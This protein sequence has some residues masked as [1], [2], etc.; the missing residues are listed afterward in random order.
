MTDESTT[1]DPVQLDDSELRRLDQEEAEIAA[2]LLEEAGEHLDQVEGALLAADRA[3]SILGS[4]DELLRSFHTI[5]GSA[6]SVGMNGL[7]HL[8]HAAETVL[9]AARK[10]GVVGD[11]DG[12]AD[13]LLR[14]VTQARSLMAAQQQALNDGALI[15][16]VPAQLR[17]GY[18]AIV[19]ELGQVAGNIAAPPAARGNNTQSASGLPPITRVPRSAISPSLGLPSDPQVP[20]A[21]ASP[22]RAPLATPVTVAP[23]AGGHTSVGTTVVK[24]PPPRAAEDRLGSAASD[25][26]GT[27]LNA[28][29]R[30]SMHRV[31]SLL[32]LVSDLT[33]C[34]SALRRHGTTE[35][36]MVELQRL[37]RLT[38]GL[39]DTVLDLRMI[40]LNGVFQRMAL[41]VRDAART[42]G[43]QVELQTEGGDVELDTI[44]VERLVDPILH[45]VRNA[46]AHGIERPEERRASRKPLPGKVWIKVTH[47]AGSITI[48][49]GDDGKGVDREKLRAAGI[50]AGLL[51]SNI[52]ATDP[53]VLRVLFEAG[54]STSSAVDSVSGRGVGMD[55]VQSNVEQA[56]G[57]VEIHSIEG[58]GTRIT[59]HVPLTLA[60][61][62]GAIIEAGDT[63]FAVPSLRVVHLASV[64]ELEL[65]P[66]ATGG[67]V[68]T[69]RGKNVPAVWLADLF[70]RTRG[71]GKVGIVVAD[72]ARRLCLVV[73][74]VRGFQ[75]LVVRPLHKAFQRIPG[76]AGGSEISEGEVGLIL[77]VAGL[78]TMADSQTPHRREA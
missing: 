61:I 50:R 6:A 59:L 52:A 31:D 48:E 44:L 43:K 64:E 20:H 1:M 40:S 28:T 4:I 36:G 38:D 78:M 29:M 18:A 33:L 16:A 17:S 11:P 73:D 71:T 24:A 27:G 25:A 65:Q 75:Q 23:R 12:T 13:L 76:I 74:N 63:L 8:A 21:G 53:R 55:V 41:T 57:T 54:I 68:A 56:G 58:R 39:R 51:P 15:P 5:K 49:I 14:A 62:D 35:A 45:I 66:V 9:T 47:D 67:A 26:L 30:V 32:N 37:V 69:I 2:V 60:I 34:V 3:S 7:S 19:A 70:G 10:A 72:A 22:P 46:V 42:L 77:D